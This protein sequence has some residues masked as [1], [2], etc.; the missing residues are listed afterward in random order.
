MSQKNDAQLVILFSIAYR[1]KSYG[2]LKE[3]SLM[4]IKKLPRPGSYI[5]FKNSINLNLWRI[6][7]LRVGGLKSELE[8][9]FWL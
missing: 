8:Q 1:I 3:L 5:L 4:K 6:L 2:K 9:Q 7:L